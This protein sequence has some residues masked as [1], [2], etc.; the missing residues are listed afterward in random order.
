MMDTLNAHDS[1]ATRK[2]L[3]G[4]TEGSP[5]EALETLRLG[6]A[7]YIRKPVHTEQPR[8]GES[9]GVVLKPR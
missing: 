4:M 8:S 1:D 9:G 5:A 7:E 6:V 2:I 3:M